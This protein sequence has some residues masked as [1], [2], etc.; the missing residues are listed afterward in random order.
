MHNRLLH[1]EEFGS[2]QEISGLS[3]HSSKKGETTVRGD[4]L[5][6]ATPPTTHHVRGSAHVSFRTV[7]AIVQGRSKKLNVLVL[8]DDASNTSYINEDVASELGLD[9]P[10]KDVA[11]NVVNG[12]SE[13]FFSIEVSFL[14]SSMDGR[15]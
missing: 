4:A 2:N 9:G 10:G 7:P 12:Q 14:V 8:L 15:Y 1:V 11:I 5:E 6:A 3:P 13:S